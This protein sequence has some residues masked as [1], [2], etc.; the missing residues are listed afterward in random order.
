MVPWI[1]G[2]RAAGSDSTARASSRG[3][4]TYTRGRRTRRVVVT[5]RRASWGDLMTSPADH[6]P[7]TVLL[8]AAEDGR[9]TDLPCPDCGHAAVDVRFT[10]PFPDE[11]RTW[12]LC[13]AC[14]F[15]MRSQPSGKP[16]YFSAGLVDR[17]LEGRDRR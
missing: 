11:W 14:R 15:E 12:F 1:G 16:T 9:L 4:P 3:A 7:L 13:R 2:E 17:M 5:R 8:R 6:S 10:H